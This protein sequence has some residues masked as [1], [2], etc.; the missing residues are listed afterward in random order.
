MHIQKTDFVRRNFLSNVLQRDKLV[1]LRLYLMKSEIKFG[2]VSVVV[3]CFS[4]SNCFCGH[5]LVIC[6]VFVAYFLVK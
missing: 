2:K 1:Y 4:P 6:H 5:R 3:F